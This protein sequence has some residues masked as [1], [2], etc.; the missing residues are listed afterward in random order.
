MKS[1]KKSA[2]AVQSFIG[3]YQQIDLYQ[4]DQVDGINGKLLQI[5]YHVIYC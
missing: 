2:K 5:K 3:D 4:S 1:S